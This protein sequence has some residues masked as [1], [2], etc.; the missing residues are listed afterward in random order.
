MPPP[1]RM[2]N[3]E[4]PGLGLARGLLFGTRTPERYRPNFFGPRIVEREGRMF[5]AMGHAMR[6]RRAEGLL[7]SFSKFLPQ[8][9]NERRP[10]AVYARPQVP[11]GERYIPRHVM[12]RSAQQERWHAAAV[13]I[14]KV[15]ERESRSISK[16]ARDL[17][18]IFLTALKDGEIRGFKQ[19]PQY[20]EQWFKNLAQQD[21]GYAMMLQSYLKK[22][23]LNMKQYCEQLTINLESR[24]NNKTTKD[25]LNMKF[26]ELGI[27]AKGGEM[28]E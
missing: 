6:N 20:L 25:A 12:E 8:A 22:H 15:M 24:F 9:R 7:G 13:E 3:R 2:M 17:Q 11:H 28:G 18:N 10:T 27:I 23:K 16:E 1:R 21:P 14:E 4:M 26:S 19:F 5:G